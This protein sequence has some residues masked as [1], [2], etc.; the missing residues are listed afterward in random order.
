MQVTLH[1]EEVL[2]TKENVYG[3]FALESQHSKMAP[4]SFFSDFNNIDIA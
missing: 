2:K 4:I 1:L 3:M